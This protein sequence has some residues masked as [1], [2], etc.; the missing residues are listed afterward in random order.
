MDTKNS[1]W[2]NP[3]SSCCIYTGFWWILRVS[4]VSELDAAFLVKVGFLF[5]ST[6]LHWPWLRRQLYKPT[7]PK[8]NLSHMLLGVISWSD[9]DP[10][11]NLLFKVL[12]HQQW[13]VI[14]HAALFNTELHLLVKINGKPKL[15]KPA[16]F[17][18]SQ[19][20]KPLSLSRL[21]RTTMDCIAPTAERTRNLNIPVC[22]L[23]WC[24]TCKFKQASFVIVEIS[25][26]MSLWPF[27]TKGTWLVGHASHFQS[28]SSNKLFLII[29][30]HKF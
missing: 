24:L 14:T 4:N 7:F 21:Q 5:C 28:S 18:L 8:L 1:S 17:F 23:K 25:F 10:T 13:F 12:C 6:P 15:K 11:V 19:L 26:I 3:S 27:V 9:L 20:N 29:V 30:S 2:A 16:M 22:F